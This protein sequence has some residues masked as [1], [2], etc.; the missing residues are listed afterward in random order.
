MNTKTVIWFGSLPA[1]VKDRARW[2]RLV[3]KPVMVTKKKMK[4]WLMS[5]N[6]R[7]QGGSG[8][9]LFINFPPLVTSTLITN[10]S[11]RKHSL[12]WT[13][14]AI[15]TTC[16]TDTIIIFALYCDGAFKISIYDL[17]EPTKQQLHNIQQPPSMRVYLLPK[18]NC[19][20]NLWASLSLWFSTPAFKT[21]WKPASHA[22]HW[23]FRSSSF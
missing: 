20:K 22:F 10:T 11:Q 23:T 2:W 7:K 15:R 5:E 18:L 6:H 3:S 19:C 4:L 12:N 14:L 8:G 13:C 21:V 1:K 17:Q 16:P 9:K